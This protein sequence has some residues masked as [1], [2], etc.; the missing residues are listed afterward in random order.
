MATEKPGNESKAKRSKKS[1]DSKDNIRASL[2]EWEEKVRQPNLV[3][4]PE[5]KR[6][7]RT[8]SD[9]PVKS[10]YTPLDVDGIVYLR[11]IGFPG[12]YTFT[13]CQMPNGY[14]S[15]DFTLSYY[16][17]FGRSESANERFRELV[18]RGATTVNS[19]A[20]LPTQLGYDSD[21]PFAEG[22][23]G[24][25]GVPLASL[26]D[27]ERLYDGIDVSKVSM[28]FGVCNCVSP[29]ALSLLLTVAENGD[30]ELVAFVEFLERFPEFVD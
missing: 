3:K 2:E 17:G 13:R 18:A 22:E 6:E 4:K 27:A 8:L 12:Q 15:H 16:S 30:I 24:K 21:D 23:V 11:D 29:Y 9:F 7:F 10:L 20:D 1:Q 25:V 5:R 14:R 28:G 26:L 19:A